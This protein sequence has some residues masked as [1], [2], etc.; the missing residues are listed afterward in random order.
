[1]SDEDDL[2]QELADAEAAYLR[3]WRDYHGLAGGCPR[4]GARPA[5]SM[6]QPAPLTPD[7]RAHL[8]ALAERVRQA[9]SRQTRGA[10]SRS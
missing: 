4:T 8:D 10:G 6:L 9:R 3:A 5:V 1:M 2:M 7:Q